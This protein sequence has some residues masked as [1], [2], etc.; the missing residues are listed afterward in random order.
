LN[1]IFQTVNTKNSKDQSKK[2]KKYQQENNTIGFIYKPSSNIE[3]NNN[4][5]KGD[6]IV[7]FKNSCLTCNL[8]KYIIIWLSIISIRIMKQMDLS[9]IY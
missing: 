4:R 1:N 3:V 5:K 6:C 7:A 2:W 9:N 8:E